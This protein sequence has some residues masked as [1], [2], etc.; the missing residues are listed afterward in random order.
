MAEISL[1]PSGEE[2]ALAG[3]LADLLAAN[4]EKPEKVKVLNTLKSRVYILAEDAEV[5]ITMD[6]DQG[7]LVIY[8]GKEGRPDISITTDSSTLLDLANINIM[9]GLPNFFDEGG[10]EI[11]KKMLK[12]D[13]KI[14][15]MFTHPGVLIKVT[16]VM[17]LN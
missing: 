13:L 8:G 5:S 16:K 9:F 4:L 2:V 17:S 10:R 6:F 14:K 15:G 11:V 12:R 1:A 7:K 3:M